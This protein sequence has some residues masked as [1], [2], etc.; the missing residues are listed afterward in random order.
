MLINESLAE[1]Q[2]NPDD[3]LGQMLVVRGERYEVV[4]V[5][6][7]MI[8]RSRTETNVFIPMFEE[9]RKK[10]KFLQVWVKHKEGEKEELETKLNKSDSKNRYKL[11]S[12]KEKLYKS[13][14]DII[15][16][17]IF[18]VGRGSGFYE[19]GKASANQNCIIRKC[20]GTLV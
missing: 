5:F 4:G 16:Y 11:E 8:R 3:A 17:A 20:C 2:G 14:R 6:K 12:E 13:F 19:S 10:A 1:K 18:F 7:D 15:G 9:T